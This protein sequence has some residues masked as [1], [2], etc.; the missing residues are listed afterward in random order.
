MCA[1]APDASEPTRRHGTSYLTGQR[2][3]TRHAVVH[4]VDILGRKADAG[5]LTA[6]RALCD[7]KGRF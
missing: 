7:D 4:V 3:Q 1:P 2:R 6:P 5:M